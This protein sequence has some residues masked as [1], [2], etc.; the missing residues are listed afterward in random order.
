[1]SRMPSVAPISQCGHS[2]GHRR[3]GSRWATCSRPRC[4]RESIRRGSQLT[5]GWGARGGSTSP[6]LR[7]HP[8]RRSRCVRPRRAR[9]SGSRGPRPACRHPAC[10]RPRPDERGPSI[11]ARRASRRPD[12][13]RATVSRSMRRSMS[14]A[15]TP[16]L[17]SA[18]T[19][20]SGCS[21]TSRMS[22][23]VQSKVASPTVAPLTQDSVECSLLQVRYGE[24]GRS[25]RPL[26]QSRTR[27]G[28]RDPRPERR[29]KDVDRRDSR[30]L[31]QA[32]PRA[33]CGCSASIR[34][35]TTGRSPSA[36]G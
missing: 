24:Q 23:T 28:A 8:P 4:P 25:R 2:G 11:W 18:A 17:P 16:R 12:A 15:G 20:D 1:M 10:G 9:G 14:S 31:P 36:S 13:A 7:P 32:L 27:R 33:A 6:L 34:S 21:R 3:S 29:W 26:L 35:V 19:T 22:I 5:G 30:G